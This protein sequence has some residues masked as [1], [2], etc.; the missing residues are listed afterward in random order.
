M[1]FSKTNR[2][3]ASN[4][5]AKRIELISRFRNNAF[6]NAKRWIRD[7]IIAFLANEMSK[8]AIFENVF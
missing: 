7:W 1:I 3:F 4:V 5:E 2:L 6:L 8:T